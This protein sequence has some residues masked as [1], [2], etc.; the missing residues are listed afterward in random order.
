M[1]AADLGAGD[2]L[3]AAFAR[4]ERRGLMMAT[5]ARS[6]SVVV[7]LGWLAVANPEHGAAYA[8]VLGTAAFLLVSGLIQ[9]WLYQ[10]G[11]AG[12]PRAALPRPWRAAR[13]Q[14]LEEPQMLE[15]LRRR[16]EE[17]D[18][19]ELPTAQQ[20]LDTILS[21]R[22][23]RHVKATCGCWLPLRCATHG[24]TEL[25]HRRPASECGNL[26]CGDRHGRG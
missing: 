21:A 7:I 13:R 5:T 19:E 20:A 11:A 2:R 16:V 23:R 9:L 8:W 14:M 3:E 12:H 10:R 6:A 25:W 24:A 17:Q 18:A 1:S 26:C 22:P 4:E 15:E